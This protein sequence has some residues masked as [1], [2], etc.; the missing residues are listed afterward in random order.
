MSQ[1]SM[2]QKEILRSYQ[3]QIEKHQAA[4]QQLKKDKKVL[5]LARFSTFLAGAVMAWYYWPASRIIF[6]ILVITAIIFIYL[7]FRD[8]DKG[9]SIKN[10]ERMIQ[11]NRHELD[12]IQQNLQDY[13][14]GHMF[15]DPTHAYAADLDL[16]GPHSLFQWL[17]RCHAEQ[18]KHLLAALLKSP[19]TPAAIKEK[20]KAATELSEKQ[21]TCQQFQSIA[22]A[23]PLS[24]NTEKRIQQWITKPAGEFEKSYWKLIRNFYPCFT[25]FIII[26]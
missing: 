1:Q 12:A 23:N 10:H 18:S 9:S 15:E 6:P 11:V 21:D 5:A 3:Q 7:V 24:I 26:L 20:Q 16:F 19:L 13:E 22:M 14:D 4:I 8:S 17:N 2:K 25:F